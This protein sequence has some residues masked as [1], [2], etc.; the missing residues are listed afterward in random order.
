MKSCFVFIQNDFEKHDIM[1]CRLMQNI[2]IEC[3]FLRNEADRNDKEEYNCISES[4]HWFR[5]VA[6]W[7]PKLN[8]YIEQN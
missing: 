7:V 4:V 8:N 1:V 3:T 6:F 2:R 5:L